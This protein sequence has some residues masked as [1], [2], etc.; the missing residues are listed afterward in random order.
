[1]TA[2]ALARPA[3]ATGGDAVLS[4]CGRWRYRLTRVW[5]PGLPP[6]GFAM[7]NPSTAD[8]DRDDPT[9][10][11][12]IA[13]ARHAGAG[14]LVVVNLL[15]LRA[16]DPAALDA[17]DDPV[18]PDNAVFLEAMIAAGGPIVCAWGAGV[19]GRVDPG[20]FLAAANAAGVRLLSLGTTR[21]G[22]PRHPLYV[23]TA[24][25]LRPFVPAAPVSRRRSRR[26]TP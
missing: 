18:G 23:P 3:A 8:G 6:L 15:A 2:A 19:A 5:D 7:L 4:P 24:T 11:R 20:P 21:D 16:T 17:A 25:P 22:H 1:L 26:S 12:C 10:L 14:S 13:I 9:L